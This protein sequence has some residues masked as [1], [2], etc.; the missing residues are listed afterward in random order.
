MNPQAHSADPPPGQAPERGPNRRRQSFVFRRHH[1]TVTGI[2]DYFFFLFGGVA[3]LF[4]AL[5]ILLKGF[6]LG[7]WQVLTLLVLWAVVSYLA[8]P[9]LHRILSQIY[10][11]NYFIGRTRTSDG[12]LGDPVNLAWR[13]EEAQIH[14][15][16]KAAGWTL[17]DDIT[18]A[19]TWGIIRST[20]ARSSYPEAPVSPLMLFGRRQDFA[21]QQEVDGDPGQRH[22]VRFWKCPSGWLLPGG[23]QADWLAAGTYDKSVGLSLF[24]L[25]VTHKIEE[26]TDIERDYIVR[27][28]TEADPEISVDVVRDFSTGYHSRNGGGDAIITDGDLPIVDVGR[29]TTDAED[30]P[31]RLDL[32][33]DATQIDQDAHSVS[34][35]A[36]TLWSRRPLQTLIGAGLVLVLLIFQA[37]DVLSILLDWDRLRADV[38]GVGVEVTASETE[39]VT[40]IVAGVLVGLSLII[41]VIQVIASISVFRGSN[42]AR[43][44]ILTLSTISVVISF[45]NYLTGDRSIAT[46]MY[47]L[48]TVALQVGVLLSLSSDSSRLFTRFSTAAAR[49][50]RQDRAIED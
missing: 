48:I 14:H 4:L 49:A 30:Y 23:L 21:Y 43:L 19:S 34:A 28:V 5:L 1:F 47:S 32:A 50:D 6:S 9:R 24:T 39:V 2:L 13:G 12:L 17:A 10:V 33:L 3:S 45:T 15:A 26:N 25:Q 36:R 37:T 35:L 31:E 44:W 16:M 41:G 42:R 27:T 40:R 11:P 29:V 46:N 7:W 38:A 18:A 22:H 20:V 8:L